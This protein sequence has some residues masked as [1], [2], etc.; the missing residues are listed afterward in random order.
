MGV[1]SFLVSATVNIVMAQRLVRK[2]CT[3][4][5]ESLKITEAMKE[6]IL[7]Q[8]KI[9]SPTQIESFAMPQTLYHGKGCS[10]CNWRGYRGRLGIF[11]FFEVTPE[12]RNYI[13]TKDFTLDGLK[14][15]AIS[16]GMKTMFEDGLDK[17]K[18]GLTTVEEV[19]RVI[20]E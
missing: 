9:S 7:A 2:I 17:A 8:L 10:V 16:Q 5:I 12:L 20:R 3:E 4:C 13:V 1:E 18:L 15:R 6:L 19:M 14:S 11:E